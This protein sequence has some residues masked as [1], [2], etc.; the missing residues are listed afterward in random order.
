MGHLEI[1]RTSTLNLKSNTKEI[2]HL[3]GQKIKS[4]PLKI[5]TK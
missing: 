4:F 5:T 2:F 1:L 3:N